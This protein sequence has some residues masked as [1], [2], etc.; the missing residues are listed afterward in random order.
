LKISATFNS[1]MIASNRFTHNDEHS[2][3]A[4]GEQEKAVVKT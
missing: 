4:V 2:S 3:K 1:E